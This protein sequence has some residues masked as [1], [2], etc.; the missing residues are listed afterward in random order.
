LN[1]EQY[2]V[3]LKEAMELKGNSSKS[4]YIYT[5]TV[6]QFFTFHKKPAHE[7]TTQDVKDYLLH[8]IKRGLDPSTINSKHSMILIFFREVIEKPEIMMPIPY[9]KRKK[10]LPTILT[11]K[12]V[13]RIINH[14]TTLKYKTIF[15]VVYSSGLRLNEVANLRIS[16]IDSKRM[17]IFVHQG[18]GNKDRYTILSK[19]ALEALREYYRAYRPEDWLFYPKCHKHKH[20]STRAIQDNFVLS[21]DAASI[22]KKCSMHSLRHA[23]ASH[24]LEN[25]TDLFSIMKL[26]GHCSLR[27]T[28]VYL[29]LSPA[30]IHKVISPLDMEVSE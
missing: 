6:K 7:I 12:E 3:K 23:F 21:R 10:K 19:K 17:Q 16:D 30:K 29:H 27:T 24:M 28:Q 11:N 2:L 13:W 4:I 15:M 14:A 8:Q 18:K 26:L 22:T 25:E 5:Q 1:N 20:L 9:L